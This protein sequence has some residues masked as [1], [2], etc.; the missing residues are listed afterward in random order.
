MTRYL[1]IGQGRVH[2]GGYVHKG[3]AG[4]GLGGSQGLTN[5]DSLLFDQVS[6]SSCEAV[7]ALGC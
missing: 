5:F 7:V 1:R 6:P 4:Q 3:T 2:Q